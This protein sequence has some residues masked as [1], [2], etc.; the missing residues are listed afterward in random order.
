MIVDTGA[1]V[2]SL[3]LILIAFIIRDFIIPL[4]VW[5]KHLNEKSYRYRFWFCLI[6]QAA[7]QINLVLFLGIFDICNRFTF[8]ISNIIIY[9]LILWNYSD[10]QILSRIR[11]GI[12]DIWDIYKKERL[13]RYLLQSFTRGIKKSYR[14]ICDLPIWNYLRKNWV[15][16]VLLVGIVIYNIWFMSYNVMEYHSYQFSDIPVHQSWIYDLE[17][18]EL[19]SNGIYPFG[20]HSMI[21]FVRAVFGFNLREIMLYT[22]V[23]QFAVLIIGV[24]LLAKEIF[25]GKFTPIAVILITSL[26]VNEGRYAAALPQEIGMYAVVGVAYFMIKYLHSDRKKFVIPSDS[27]IRRVFRINSYI[28]RKYINSELL[29]LMLSVTLVIS[30]HYY[31]AIATIFIVAAIGL[32]YILKIFRKQYFVPLLFSGIMGAIIAIVP[33]GVALVK[34][35]PFQESIDWATTV[36]S[37]E[38]WHGS[39]ADYQDELAS[40]LGQE[41]LE[42]GSIDEV[43]EEKTKV[44]YSEMSFKEKL[45]YYYES[46]YNFI[47][48]KMYNHG[49]TRLMLACMAIGFLCALVMLIYRKTRNTGFDYIALIFVMILFYT[50]GASQSLGI[51]ELIQ[52]TRASTFAQ[53]FIGFI[54]ILPVDFVFRILDTWKNYRLHIA[55]NTLSLSMC[56]LVT[57]VIIDMGLYHKIFDVNQAYYNESEYVLRNIKKS[58]DDYSYTIVSPTEEYYDVIDYG[59]HTQISKFV[60]M[61]NRN[62][63]AFTFTTDYVFFF[64][65]KVVLQD[66][67]YGRVRVNKELALKEFVYMGDAQDYFYQRA[68]IES[69]A[70]YWAKAF[71][72]M[73][74][75]NFKVYFEN[76]LYIVYIM[77]QN[78]YYPYELQIDYLD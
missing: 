2:I 8:I 50:L 74:P 27:K 28:N 10:K 42:D 31:T 65:E 67:N 49:A 26:I 55:I 41:P 33:T 72:E 47:L 56:G 75:R 44:D 19:F 43:S 64:I 5:R 25:V 35:I 46:I 40:A 61:V 4:F 14:I 76:D 77:E 30:Y 69:Q 7:I 6:T 73:Y 53:P 1:Y 45:Q 29:M 12:N 13:G 52:A 3:I 58:F 20:M 17:Q 60:N 70:Y 16:T 71:A 39:E 66:Y 68:I 62:E 18:G 15:E 11:R 59:R 32:A 34:G 37:G 21:Y 38:E 36:M 9:L 57:F 78:T 48:S 22:G 24:Y 51:P 63:E 54:Y 23:Y